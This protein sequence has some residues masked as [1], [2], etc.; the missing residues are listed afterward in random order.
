MLAK[1]EIKHIA[2]LAR[3]GLTEKEIER[4]QK[5]LS[6]ILDYVEKLKEVDVSS[7]EPTS[8][9]VLLKNVTRKDEVFKF[10]KK[11]IEGYLKVKSVLK[12]R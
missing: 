2:K 11:L 8:H 12:G 6:K 9:S 5:E 4:F 7:V 10:S 3:L 1:E